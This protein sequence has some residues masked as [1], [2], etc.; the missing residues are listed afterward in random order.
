MNRKRTSKLKLAE[1]KV[2]HEHPYDSVDNWVSG[3]FQ[4][5]P[6]IKSQIDEFQKRL[7]S[8]FGADGAI[9]LVWSGDRSYG[10]EI[11]DG[12]WNSFGEPIGKFV[13]KP[14]LLFGEYKVNAEDIFYISCPR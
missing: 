8:A 3:D 1:A 11:C 7:D 10:D 6:W 9:V 5:P 2:N 4:R 14:V 13:H 12:P